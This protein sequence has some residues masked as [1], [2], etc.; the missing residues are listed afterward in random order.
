MNTQTLNEKL[1]LIQ[2]ISSIEDQTIIKKLTEFRKKEVK[3]WWHEISQEEKESIAKGLKQA[4]N[5]ELQSHSQVK[6]LYEKW[7]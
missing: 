6:K 4:E 7:L 3:D 2:W 1:M 5:G